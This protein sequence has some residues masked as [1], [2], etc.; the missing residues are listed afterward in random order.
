MDIPIHLAENSSFFQFTVRD[1]TLVR[2]VTMILVSALR[3]E[4]DRILR[5]HYPHFAG[6]RGFILDPSQ[7]PLG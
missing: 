6:S 3:P 7:A 5:T 4:R 1:L 2:S